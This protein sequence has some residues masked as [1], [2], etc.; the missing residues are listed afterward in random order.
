M[1]GEEDLATAE[2][3][4]DK[5]ELEDEEEKEVCEDQFHPGSQSQAMAPAIISIHPNSRAI[6][7]SVGAGF[8]VFDLE[9][10]EAVTPVDDSSGHRAAIRASGFSH[11]GAFFA[12]AGD[13][14]L[15]KLWDTFSW[16]CSKTI[17]VNKKTSAVAFSRDGQ[18]LL[19][20]DK[21]GVVYVIPTLAHDKSD[22]NEEPAQLLAHCCSIITS[23]ETSPCGKFV[24]TA[25]RDYKIRV[26][27]LPKNPMLGA[28][29]IQS[30][31][32]DHTSFVSCLAFVGDGSSEALLVSGGGDSTIRLWDH[33]SG[34]LLDTINIFNLLQTDK[35]D[36]FVAPA[37]V[38]TSASGSVVASTIERLTGVILLRCDFGIKKLL[39]LQKIS[40]QE[41]ICPTGLQFDRKERLWLVAGAAET[42]E[43]GDRALKPE[44]VT[45]L[46]SLAQASAAGAL[47]RLR[48]I[49]KSPATSSYEALDDTE[50]P[51]GDR[52]LKV[53]QGSPSDSSVSVAA[54]VAEAAQAA[55][56]AM[57]NLLSKRQ[58]TETHR[59]KRKR[60]RNDKKARA[61]TSS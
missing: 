56:L 38:N 51:G 27:V 43:V 42:R 59:E 45:E 5:D 46:T 29:E 54:A 53:L 2:A 15:V 14:K 35:T 33:V 17:P 10:N 34:H 41:P 52:M 8:R 30:F 16:K 36:T 18:W 13:D 28:Y 20:A 55:E 47:T 40:W 1:A 4:G 49:Q 39:F 44:Q 26:S 60:T 21:F 31:C 37:V 61:A 24:V 50:V 25:D 11:D 23:L 48:V 19:V 32:L 12:S 58:Y 7:V 22:T 57:K 3:E 6:V 9:S